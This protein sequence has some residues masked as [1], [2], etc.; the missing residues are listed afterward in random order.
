[1]FSIIVGLFMNL[2]YSDWNTT[3]IVNAVESF[4]TIGHG[5]KNGDTQLTRH[6]T[7]WTCLANTNHLAVPQ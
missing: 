3:A 7:D 2:V 1:M 4:I 6:Y 5:F